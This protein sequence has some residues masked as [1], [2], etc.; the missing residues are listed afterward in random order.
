MKRKYFEEAFGAYC[1]YVSSDENI[2]Q[3]IIDYLSKRVKSNKDMI[4]KLLAITNE[5]PCFPP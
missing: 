2:E 3:E 1:E 4:E 5:S